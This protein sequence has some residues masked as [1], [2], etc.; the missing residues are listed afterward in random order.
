MCGTPEYLAPEILDKRGHGKAVDWYSLGALMYEM[1]TGLPPFYTRDREKLFERIRRGELTYPSYITAIAKNL[2]QQLLTGYIS[3]TAGTSDSYCGA[4]LGAVAAGSVLALY[5]G[6]CHHHGGMLEKALGQL[7]SGENAHALRR[8]LSSP[9]SKLEALAKTRGAKLCRLAW[10]PK[11]VPARST[12]SEKADR[13]PSDIGLL[14]HLRPLLRPSTCREVGDVAWAFAR[15]TLLEHSFVSGLL[16]SY[17]EERPGD[18]VSLA[19]LLWAVALV[20]LS[21]PEVHPVL[22][23]HD[24]VFQEAK[25]VELI[26]LLWALGSLRLAH[27]I[28]QRVSEIIWTEA[29]TQ[30]M[31][32]VLWAMSRV[33]ASP[34]PELLEELEKRS[35]LRDLPMVELVACITALAELR[36]V[37]SGLWKKVEA[38]D[39]I[40]TRALGTLLWAHATAQVLPPASLSKLDVSQ[41][42]PQSLANSLWAQAKLHVA[43]TSKNITAAQKLLAN[44]LQR[45]KAQEYAGCIW[46]IGSMET[47][48]V[49]FFEVLQLPRS[50]RALED[51]HLSQVAWAFASA[52]VRR[53]DVMNTLATEMLCRDDF[54]LQAIANIS[55]AF[56]TLEIQ[57]VSLSSHLAGLVARRLIEVNGVPSRQDVDSLLG[58]L[59]ANRSNEALTTAIASSLQSLGRKMDRATIDSQDSSEIQHIEALHTDG[60][61]V[62][63]RAPGVIVIDKPGDWEVDTERSTE[64]SAGKVKT[65]SNFINGLNLGFKD[66][67]VGRL[68]TPS[69]G[70]LL[71]ALSY[72]GLFWLQAQRELGLFERDYLVLSHGWFPPNLSEISLKLRRMGRFAE[73][74]PYGRPACTRVKLVAHLLEIQDHQEPTSSTS[75]AS[76]VSLLALRIETGRM[77]Q[78]RSHLATLGY[79]VLGDQR[80]GKRPSFFVKDAPH[81]LHRYR[82]CFRDINHELQDVQQPL[83]LQL[84]D[85]LMKCSP[86]SPQDAE[87]LRPWLEGSLLS[88]AEDPAK[89]LGGGPSDGEEVKGHPF[90]SGID[91]TAIQQRRVTPPFKPNVS[92]G[93]DVK[94]FDKEFVDLPVVNSEVADGAHLRDVNHF[95]G[96]TYQASDLEE[97]TMALKREWL[98]VGAMHSKHLHILPNLLV[99]FVTCS[100][101]E[102]NALALRPHLLIVFMTTGRVAL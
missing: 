89:R 20:Q 90:Y 75:P 99:A 65:L 31:S 96:F 92:E 93:G 53:L 85:Y 94:Y 91:W 25:R 57:H 88:W 60:P 100:V 29:K 23:V 83:P 1:L 69:S 98:V 7:L 11:A 46:A 30:D 19:N 36:N 72:E 86:C 47:P 66:G 45:F 12:S 42:S 77:H 80:Y 43:I 97:P 61:Q 10:D 54:S 101:T 13:L 35:E 48:A 73:A 63:L 28:F 40:E 26:R 33:S 79:P 37:S 34:P 22:H 8:L 76:P 50:L 38:L 51:H 58:I 44:Q 74:S 15:H 49:E 5:V 21:P 3:N 95:E 4:R 67:F 102:T 87:K 56:R 32:N 24:K 62:V 9:R 16:K 81:F 84:R 18:P 82:L 52:G 71:H 78:I 6:P 68:D 55:W 2:L 64:E 41:M 27:P 39:G 14:L 17:E 70:L 59:W